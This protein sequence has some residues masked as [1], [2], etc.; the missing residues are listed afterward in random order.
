MMSGCM[1]IASQ[2]RQ[3]YERKPVPFPG[4]WT[5]RNSTQLIAAPDGL[6]SELADLDTGIAS[7]MQK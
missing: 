2:K 1:Y 7:R 3:L 5:D 4:L 6:C